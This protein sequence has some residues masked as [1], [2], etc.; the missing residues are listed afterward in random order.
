[1][2][3]KVYSL[4]KIYLS[5]LV[6]ISLTLGLLITSSVEATET[7]EDEVGYSVQAYLPDNQRD[8]GVSYF[9]LLVE[10]EETYTLQVEIYNH[11]AQELVVD[12]T[13]TTA[14]TN[15]NGLIV[16]EVQEDFDDSLKY[17]ISELVSIEETQV[18]VPANETK[19][20][21]I[22]LQIPNVPFEGVML[23][24]L[25][26][27]KVLDEDE[28]SDGV[29]I[30]NQYA[31]VIGLQAT[32]DEQ[33]DDQNL[34]LASIK[35]NLV[36][37]RTAV[38]ARIQNDQPILMSKIDIHA[39]VFEEGSDNLIK[40][41]DLENAQFAPNSTMDFTIDWENEYLEPGDYRLKMVATDTEN[42]EEWTWDEPFSITEEESQIS[43]DAVEL[44][45]DSWLTPTFFIIV[46]IV[47]L[48][49][50]GI[51]YYKYKKK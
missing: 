47:L 12:I 32:E 6:A 1:M 33:A 21:D 5:I 18:N 49:I 38:V 28:T 42:N 34:N 50:I 20:V 16:Y 45:E 24:G 15:R 51:L 43:E 25:E 31:Y 46:I 26:F 41:A 14:S 4:K 7:Q 10:P 17:P 30:N 39:E 3:K 40:T 11:K 36:N 27:K 22:T 23:G 8:T 29:Q 48:I 37:Y 2:S 19:V 44:E 35:P 13:P 9:D